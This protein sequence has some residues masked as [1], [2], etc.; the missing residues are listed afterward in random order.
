MGFSLQKEEQ[1]QIFSPL[2]NNKILFR[3]SFEKLTNVMFYE[4]LQVSKNFK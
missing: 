3:G 4:K 2:H 1:Y